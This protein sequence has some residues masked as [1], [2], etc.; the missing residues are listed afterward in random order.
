[1]FK[2]NKEA[3]KTR[4]IKFRL[5]ENTHRVFSYHKS[6]CIFKMSHVQI[7]RGPWTTQAREYR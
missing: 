4:K 5:I 3:D 6:L 2:Q 7:T 1:M